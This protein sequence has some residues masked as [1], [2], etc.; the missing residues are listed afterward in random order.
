MKHTIFSLTIL[1][2]LSVF[3]QNTQTAADSSLVLKTQLAQPKLNLLSS[4][5]NFVASSISLLDESGH[6]TDVITSEMLIQLQQE[7][8]LPTIRIGNVVFVIKAPDFQREEYMR[9]Q[10]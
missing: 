4:K 2:S 7:G 1:L 9:S 8:K 10:E 6:E 5:P 3:A